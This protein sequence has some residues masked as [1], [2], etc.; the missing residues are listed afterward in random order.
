MRHKVENDQLMPNLSCAHK[1]TNKISDVITYRTVLK[2]MHRKI[3]ISVSIFGRK[4]NRSLSI[5]FN[6]PS[7]TETNARAPVVCQTFELIQSCFFLFCASAVFLCAYF[8]YRNLNC[9]GQFMF[10]IYLLQMSEFNYN[11]G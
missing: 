1:N 3:L 8:S 6:L 4:S 9:K 10:L 11:I 7:V 2:S 5:R